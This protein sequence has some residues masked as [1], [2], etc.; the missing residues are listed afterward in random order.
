MER[1]HCNRC[2]YAW[3]PR[4]EQPPKA[5]PA[6]GSPYWNK[7]R[8]WLDYPAEKRAKPRPVG[9]LGRSQAEQ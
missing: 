2:G 5:C 6:C 9:R 3:F 4:Q 7:P 8:V 1:L